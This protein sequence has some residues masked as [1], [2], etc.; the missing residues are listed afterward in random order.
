V[1]TPMTPTPEGSA[2]SLPVRS[3][4]AAFKTVESQLRSIIEI[5]PP[6]SNHDQVWSPAFAPCLMEAC[7]QLDSLWKATAGSPS[8]HCTIKSHFTRFSPTVAG[9]WVVIW[10]H[11]GRDIQPFETWQCSNSPADTDYQ[12]LP[13]WQ[14]YNELKHSRWDNVRRGT[15]KSTIDAV[16]GL[17]LAIARTP[18][19]MDSICEEGWFR[20]SYGQ[21]WAIRKLFTSGES[22][23]LGITIESSLFSYASGSSD[24]AFSRSLAYYHNCSHRF[25]R[26][27]ENKYGKG[28][29][30]Y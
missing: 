20:S 17:F 22:P 23:D 30:H 27:L 12:P 10:G 19:C 3:V 11:E 25:G 13:W 29:L 5:V 14:S 26:W 6:V 24:E 18:E 2:S 15:L 16:A 4:L 21:T 8:E 9:R 7:T 28:F 1:V